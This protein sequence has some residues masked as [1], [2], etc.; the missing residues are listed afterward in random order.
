[1]SKKS[2]VYT[3][4]GD[5]GTTG[6]VGGERIS[7]AN[8]RIDLYGEVDE[9]NSHVGVVRSFLD[10]ESELGYSYLNSIQVHLFNIGSIMACYSEGREKYKLPSVDQTNIEEME[11]IIDQLDAQV[12]KMKYFILP[13]GSK[14]SAF[15]HICRTVTRR[16]ERKA[17]SFQEENDGDLPEEIIKYL[18]RLSDFFFVLARFDNK[19]NGI[20]ETPWI[21]NP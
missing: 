9:L 15:L 6:L 11:K 14:V 21:P 3:R 8:P 16:V 19:K 5:K 12:E 1:M 18:N 17:I 2:N 4:S 7:K 10:N 20:E 13:G